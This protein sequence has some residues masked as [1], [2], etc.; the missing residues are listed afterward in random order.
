MWIGCALIA[1]ALWGCSGITGL[2]GG[3]RGAR[4]Q[5]FATALG[6]AGS[7][8]G[9]AVAGA[10]LSG[11]VSA[12]IHFRSVLP[13]QQ[14]TLR[15][16]ALAAFF[17]VPVFFIG[18]MGSIYGL[19][20]WEQ[21]A[22]PRTGQRVRLCYGLLVASMA[23]VAL[24]GD[25]VMFLFAWEVMALCAFFLVSTE[26]HKKEVREAG[27]L[28]LASTHA[29]T[30]I[31]FALFALL[32]LSAGSFELLPLVRAGTGLRSA[33]FFTSLAG[34]G[35]KAGCRKSRGLVAGVMV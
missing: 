20:Y 11:A 28:Y 14:F 33:V 12:V 17:L 3:S 25:G 27:W 23:L 9:L 32:R 21:T 18:L 22:H 13:G 19:G 29:G 7:G 8:I 24:A 2:L 31:L 15:L 26:D 6:A 10:A 5:W 16:D 34:F 4:S 35:F 30:L 1:I